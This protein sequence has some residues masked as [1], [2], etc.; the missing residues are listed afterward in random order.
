MLERQGVTIFLNG[1]NFFYPGNFL[2]EHP[3]NTL[4]KGYLGAGSSFA[5]SP[6]ANFDQPFFI[7]I[8]ELDITAVSLKIRAH[9]I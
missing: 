1:N 2:L 7:N 8:Y 9:F 5:S 6:Q 4:L 3:L